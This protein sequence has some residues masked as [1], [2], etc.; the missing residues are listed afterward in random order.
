MYLVKL[1]H[2]RTIPPFPPQT[3]PS[4]S[5]FTSSYIIYASCI[6]MCMYTVAHKHTYVC[7]YIHMYVYKWRCTIYHSMYS[8]QWYIALTKF[9]QQLICG[10]MSKT[11][12]QL[13]YNEYLTW[14]MN[15]IVQYVYITSTFPCGTALQLYIIYRI[16]HTIP[17]PPSSCP[18]SQC[19]T[20]D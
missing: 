9:L 6:H 5:C 2:I 3:V 18:G 20:C 14:M 15:D 17:S 7:A 16:I 8:I 11:V 10:N 19:P 1:D 4:P 13:I 12:L